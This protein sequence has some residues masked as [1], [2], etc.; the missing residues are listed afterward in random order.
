MQLENTQT[1]EMKAEKYNRGY[2]VQTDREKHG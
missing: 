2:K 1:R